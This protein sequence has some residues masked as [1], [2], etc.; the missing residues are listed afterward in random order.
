[1]LLSSFGRLQKQDGQNVYQ[2]NP[3]KGVN[4]KFK[5]L[6]EKEMIENQ[7]KYVI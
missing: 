2:N 6:N 5:R 7:F 1:M 3:K 4:L